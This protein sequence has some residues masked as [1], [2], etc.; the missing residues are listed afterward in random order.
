MYR[1]AKNLIKFFSTENPNK[2][3]DNHFGFKDV[4]T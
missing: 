2:S 3:A 1:R 4:P